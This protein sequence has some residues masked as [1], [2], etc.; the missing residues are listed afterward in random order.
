MREPETCYTE[1]YMD[2]ESRRLLEDTF[3]LAKDN[4]RMLRAVRR[5]Q[6]IG[7]FGK[8]FIW[9]IVLAIAAYSYFAFLQPLLGKLHIPWPSTA[10]SGVFNL[11]TTTPFGK[12]INYF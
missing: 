1:D 11:S 10:Q 2:P 6:I 4:H 8:V 12:L 9:L 5:H 3:A 7:S